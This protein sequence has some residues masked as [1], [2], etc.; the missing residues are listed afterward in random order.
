MSRLVAASGL[1]AHVGGIAI[2]HQ[3]SFEVDAGEV[4]TLFGPSGAGKTTIA[5]LVLGEPAPGVCFTG[6]LD[7]A[8]GGRRAG[9][10]YLPQHAGDT[11]NPSR[12]IGASLA[13]LVRLHR[14]ESCTGGRGSVTAAV[15]EVLA[16]AAYPVAGDPRELL[17]R[18]PWQF[19]GG[20]R[21]RLALAQVLT[22]RPHLLVLDEPTAGL[23]TEARAGVIDQIRAQRARGLGVLLI[24][25]DV[26]VARSL[27]DAIYEIDHGRL[28]PRRLAGQLPATAD[29]TRAPEP[30]SGIPLA[31][32]SGL[33]VRHG[34]QVA[35]APLDLTLAAGEV[36]VV[37]G[38]SGAGKSTLARCLVGLD[39]PTRGAVCWRGQRLPMARNRSRS[40]LADIQYVWQEAAASFDRFRPILTQCV[41][42]AVNLRRRSRSDA[43]RSVLAL[44]ERVGL[45]PAQ[46][47][48]TS[49]GLSGGQ[50]QRAALVRALATEPQLLVCDEVTTA[51]DHEIAAIVLD[52]IRDWQQTSGSAVLL[53]SHLLG[54]L[55]SMAHRLAVLQAGRLRWLGTMSEAIHSH[56]E[57]LA[58]LLAARG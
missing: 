11:L 2:L 57:L 18:Y 49:S 30:E 43:E 55:V 4:V 47:R 53:I 54:P 6:K 15:L 14:P 13:D 8:A 23:D 31:E 52:C 32:F 26:H 36:L 37:M 19:S 45:S 22:A 33:E 3:V 40:Q 48:R 12:R 25:H 7:V 42:A 46:V 29:P 28:G 41:D 56:D 21:Q 39:R 10:G 27:S 20:Q 17:R 38:S 34:S 24:T 51:L 35:L 44:F 58:G 16:E 5:S 50:L 9:I 1:T